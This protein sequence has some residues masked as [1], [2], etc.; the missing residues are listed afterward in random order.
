[1]SKTAVR[2]QAR[3]FLEFPADELGAVRGR[4]ER[5]GELARRE[6]P[7]IA[8]MAQRTPPPDP[9]FLTSETRYAETHRE[10]TQIEIQPDAEDS[11][12]KARGTVRA[13][14]ELADD[15]IWHYAEQVQGLADP[16]RLLERSARFDATE[17]HRLIDR[18]NI[19]RGEVERL[20]QLQRG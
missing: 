9:E 6:E 3:G 7:K 14:A 1:M 5:A 2:E 16:A 10:I 8:A 20:D 18:M 15:L 19:W 17:V 13:L 11:M 4:V 12:V